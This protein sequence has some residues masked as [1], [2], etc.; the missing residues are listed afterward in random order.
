MNDDTLASLATLETRATAVRHMLDEAGVL[1]STTRTVVDELL[2]ELTSVERDLAQRAS[3][4]LD[5]DQAETVPVRELRLGD[6]IREWGEADGRWLPVAAVS[7]AAD[8][9]MV[10][11]G[12]PPVYDTMYGPNETVVELVPRPVTA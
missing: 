2:T 9:V 7:V 11:V 10:S 8:R 12:K 3:S 6:M 1:L 4:S 5:H